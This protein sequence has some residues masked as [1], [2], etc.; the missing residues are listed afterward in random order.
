MMQNRRRFLL[1]IPFFFTTTAAAVDAAV[2]ST[3]SPNDEFGR[4]VDEVY[5]RRK[6]QYDDETVSWQELKARADREGEILV[7]EWGGIVWERKPAGWPVS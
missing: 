5:A 4:D 6:W 3:V 7:F 1:G 2:S